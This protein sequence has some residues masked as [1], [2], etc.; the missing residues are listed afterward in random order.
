MLASYL[1]NQKASKS[2]KAKKLKAAGIS[3]RVSAL[4]MCRLILV[5]DMNGHQGLESSAEDD[6]SERSD[7]RVIVLLHLPFIS[8]Y[9]GFCLG[10]GG[11][12]F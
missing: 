10:Y 3:M 5:A 7:E 1:V 4:V 9:E 2:S 11:R 6:E 8:T 12:K